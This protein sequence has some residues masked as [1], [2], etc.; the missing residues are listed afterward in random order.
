[1]TGNQWGCRRLGW[2]NIKDGRIPY[3]RGKAGISGDF[4]IIPELATELKYV[5]AGQLLFLT[6]TG[7]R[8]YTTESLGNWFKDRCKDA[9]IPHCNIHGV[10]KTGATQ[11]ADAGAIEQQISTFLAHED[12][13]QAATYTKKTNIPRMID[14]GFALLERAKGESNVSTLSERLDK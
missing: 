13:R 9:G 3:T 14:A 12:T 10:R 11:L 2:Q 5:P 8:D 4:P 7:G 6:H 1:M